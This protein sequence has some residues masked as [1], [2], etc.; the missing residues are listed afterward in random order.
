LPDLRAARSE[1]PVSAINQRDE[2]DRL[3]HPV[4]SPG[5]KKQVGRERFVLQTRDVHEACYL[6]PNKSHLPRLTHA[7][8]VSELSLHNYSVMDDFK[9]PTCKT[10]QRRKRKLEA[11][12]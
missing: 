6:G 8:R 7:C 12:A 5:L 3:R 2:A 4:K 10:C 1:V 9:E 11:G